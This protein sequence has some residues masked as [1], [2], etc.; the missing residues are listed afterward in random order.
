MAFLFSYAIRYNQKTLNILNMKFRLFKYLLILSIFTWSCTP[1]IITKTVNH[2]YNNLGF[3]PDLETKKTAEG[4]LL[5]IKPIDAKFLNR[6]AFDAATRDGNYEKELTLAIEQEKNQMNELNKSERDWMQGK[7]NAIDVI[8]KFVNEGEIPEEIGYSLKTRIW[9]G[10]EFGRDGSEISSL[11]EAEDFNAYFNP[12]NLNNKYLS[13]FKVTT[14]NKGTEIAKVKIDDFQ[15]VSGEEQL[16]PLK[17]N[18]FE[19]NLSEAPE[20]VKNAYRFNMPEELVVTPS[21]KIT[22]YL[23]IPAINPNKKSLKVQY[24]NNKSFSDFEFIMNNKSV[25]KTYE[26]EI[27][28]LVSASGSSS[29]I[30]Y[31][32]AIRYPNGQL[33]TT[34]KP[35][36]FIDKN[37][38]RERIDIYGIAIGISSG[39]VYFSKQE[40]AVSELINN[41]AKLDFK[42]I[43]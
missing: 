25:T 32:Y 24:I 17:M 30:A 13:V 27:V 4:L 20:K 34:I 6:E 14:E 37:R 33:F 11:S 29:Y 21:Q 40:L 23:A 19:E 5:T 1:K 42:E 9:F 38:K 3:E 15:I 22:K 28:R 10:P 8:T 12:F 16:Y 2:S 18:Y 31:F 39:R 7:L 41:V 43:K 35:E 26:L 36:F